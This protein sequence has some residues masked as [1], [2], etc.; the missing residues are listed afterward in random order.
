MPASVDVAVIG[1]GPAGTTLAN[2]VA[3][4]GWSVLVLEKDRHPRFHIGESLLPHNIRIFRRLGL[5][6]ALAKEYG[7]SISGAAVAANESPEEQPEDSEEPE[8]EKDEDQA[9]SADEEMES[10]AR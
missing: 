2:L 5:E 9:E 10:A 8:E 1:G 6:Q 4:A 7:L 3:R